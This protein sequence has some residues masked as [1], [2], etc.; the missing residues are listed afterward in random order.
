MR[1][2][3]IH[4]FSCTLASIVP[5]LPLKE[6]VGTRKAEALDWPNKVEGR[7]L[8]ML[9]LSDK[10]TR[11]LHSFPGQVARFSDGSREIILRQVLEPTRKL[12]PSADCFKATGYSIKPLSM[13][14]DQ[15][16]NRW[17]QFEAIKGKEKLR[18]R[19]RIYDEAGNNWADVSSW[20]WA[21]LLKRAS[22]GPWWAVTIA[23]ASVEPTLMEQGQ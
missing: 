6:E 14:V 3:V 13:F 8:T 1:T 17:S 16:K 2:I 23:E 5:F 9:P 4:I 20:Y 10:E 7:A 19:E 15:E 21:T 18:V 11:F 12:H 22:S